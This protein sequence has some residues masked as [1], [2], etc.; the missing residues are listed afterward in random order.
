M[1]WIQGMD[2]SYRKALIKK[3]KWNEREKERHTEQLKV[4]DNV[5]MGFLQNEDEDR[6]ERKKV[7]LP[8]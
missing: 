1:D 3:T 5:R 4:K 2:I 7:T 6:K 8:L